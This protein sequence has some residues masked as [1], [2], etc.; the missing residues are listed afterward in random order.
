MK[1]PLLAL[2]FIA[3]TVLCWGMYGP[4]LHKG[5]IGMESSRLR[6]LLCVGLAYFAIAVIVPIA[7]LMT[8]G[9]TGKFSLS[10]IVWSSAAGVAGVGG[11]LGIILAL[12][13]GGTPV[14]VMPLV[15]GGAPIVN[16][17]ISMWLSGAF[18]RIREAPELPDFIF[19]SGL[20]LVSIGAFMVLFFAPK[21]EAHESAAAKQQPSTIEQPAQSP[22]QDRTA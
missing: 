4:I 15:F 3:M 11:A 13:N 18:Q 8:S 1:F 19:V 14:W 12:T 9:E 2:P 21:G 5:Q 10:G 16:A 17:F 20:I 22:P 7:V 6:P